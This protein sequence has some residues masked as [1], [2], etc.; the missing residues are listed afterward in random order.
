[1][2]YKKQFIENLGNNVRKL[3][4][5]KKISIEKLSIKSGISYS[6]LIRIEKGKINTSIYQ[7]YQIAHHLEVKL[8]DFFTE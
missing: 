6:Q 7:L 2:L 5:E 4:S 8:E 1:M 3:R